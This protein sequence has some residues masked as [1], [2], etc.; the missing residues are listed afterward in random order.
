MKTL[1]AGKFPAQITKTRTVAGLVL[2]ETLYEPGQ[3]LEEHS[4]TQSGF[5][6]VLKGQFRERLE[7]KDRFCNSSD[8][9]FRPAEQ[10]HSDH[11]EKT[12]ARCFNVQFNSDWMLRLQ[13]GSDQRITED[14]AYFSGGSLFHAGLR[15]YREF[16]MP[17]L[18]SALI[19]EGL[20]L[21]MLGEASSLLI[22]A[23]RK[24]CPDWISSVREIIH[25]HFD[26]PLTITDLAK[27]ADVHPVYL[28]RAFRRYYKQSIGE[29]VRSLKMEFAKAQ[30]SSTDNP[31]ADIANEAGFY[32]QSHFS[33]TFRRFADMTPLQ[34]R[35]LFRKV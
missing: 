17:D 23:N 34:Y 10:R 25:D 19:I 9:I 1:G 2:A 7:K 20:A 30:L 24:R 16:R 29:Y 21:E 31:I 15:L 5:I 35:K 12:T 13:Q 22:N 26:A 11:F 6:V 32:D 28:N 3:V 8:V 18:H 14:P 4:H 27:I 33:R